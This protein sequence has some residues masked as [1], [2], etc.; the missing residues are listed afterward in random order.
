MTGL[1]QPVVVGLSGGLGNQVF[2]Y[3]AVRWLSASP[4]HLFWTY[5]G[6]LA[7][8]TALCP[9][10]IQYRPAPGYICPH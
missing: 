4:C 3:A 8:G 7:R 1:L 2:Q 6:L 9:F 5:H 10:P